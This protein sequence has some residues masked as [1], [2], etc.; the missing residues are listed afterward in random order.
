MKITVSEL[1]KLVKE[2]VEEHLDER[3]GIGIGEKIYSRQDII[4]MSDEQ[5]EGLKGAKYQ[6]TNSPKIVSI[7]KG[8]VG[9]QG[10]I[11]IHLN[12]GSVAAFNRKGENVTSD[13]VSKL[14]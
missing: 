12:N 7:Y 2:A 1:K 4:K 11:V 5:I 9:P 13:L 14:Y 6:M 10:E 3:Y 8:S